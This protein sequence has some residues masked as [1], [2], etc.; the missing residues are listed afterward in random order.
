MANGVVYYPYIKPP[1]NEWFSR[2]LLYWDE[3]YSIVPSE[4]AFNPHLYNKYVGDLVSNDLVEPL[5]PMDYIHKVPDFRESFL[6]LMEKSLGNGIFVTK[7]TPKNS[8][9]IHL[10]KLGKIASDLEK[11][12]IAKHAYSHWYYVEKNTAD[13][14]MAYLAGLLCNVHR[15]NLEPITDN[16]AN[17]S[18]YEKY[19]DAD[20]REL[21]LV[22]MRTETLDN[23]LPGPS[24]DLTDIKKIVEFKENNSSLMRKYRIHVEKLLLKLS[25]IDDEFLRKKTFDLFLEESRDDIEEIKISLNNYWNKIRWGTLWSVTVPASVVSANLFVNNLPEAIRN[26]PSLVRAIV[27]AF[28]SE[29]HLQRQIL[30]NPLSYAVKVKREF[31]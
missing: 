9:I 1:E 30:Q 27:N 13:L 21:R 4:H 7:L 17:L 31:Q 14:F 20:V 16:T 12:K 6:T 10:E 28:E 15:S 3:V 25:L 22:K 19:F 8:E 2:T 11:L 26:L 23:L 24:G 5:K 29:T 18:I